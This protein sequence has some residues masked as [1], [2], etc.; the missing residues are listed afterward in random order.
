MKVLRRRPSEILA[1]H[2]GETLAIAHRYEAQNVRVFGS[3]AGGEDTPESD[4][5]LLVDLEPGATLF[6]LSIFRLDMV[7][8]LGMEV[9]IVP[10]GSGDSIMERILSEAVPLVSGDPEDVPVGG[11]L[12]RL[13]GHSQR[14]R[15]A[16]GSPQS[17]P[18]GRACP[19]SG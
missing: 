8:L 19:S 10:S 5:D 16:N 9:D 3:L 1:E 6:D 17:A 2:R 12:V 18:G 11:Q 13:R 4:V 7:D 15:V 14:H